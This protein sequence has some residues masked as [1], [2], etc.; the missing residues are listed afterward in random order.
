MRRIFKSVKSEE[1]IL[2]NQ[3]SEILSDEFICEI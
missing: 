1:E 3:G 2:E